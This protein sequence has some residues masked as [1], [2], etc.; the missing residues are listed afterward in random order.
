VKKI[1]FAKFNSIKKFND[2]KSKVDSLS[3]IF[4]L[5]SIF[6]TA[7]GT[8]AYFFQTPKYVVPS[9]GKI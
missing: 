9:G 8:F 7:F 4:V 1:N 5:C 2:K 6:L 3:K